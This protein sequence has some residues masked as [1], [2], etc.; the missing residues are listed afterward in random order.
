MNDAA[1]ANHAALT[2]FT[3]LDPDRIALLLDQTLKDIER[4][5]Y[6]ENYIVLEPGLTSLKPLQLLWINLVTDGL[7]ALA[8]GVAWGRAG[9]AEEAERVFLDLQRLGPLAEPVQCDEIV[10][11]DGVHE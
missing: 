5:L 6:F 10:V 4:V 1:A 2:A 3:H 11:H 8:L 7:P 9:Q